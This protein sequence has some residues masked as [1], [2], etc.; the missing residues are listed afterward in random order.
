MATPSFGHVTEQVRLTL[1]MAAAKLGTLFIVAQKTMT[2]VL[3]AI[4][5]I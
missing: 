4:R 5:N 3:R 2:R 1:A